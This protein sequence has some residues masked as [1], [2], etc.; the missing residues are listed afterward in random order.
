M[1]S[2][3]IVV[4]RFGIVRFDDGFS[5]AEVARMRSD[6]INEFSK[7]QGKVVLFTDLSGVTN[8]KPEVRGPVTKVLIADNPRVERNAI[9]VSSGP[10]AMQAH[11]VIRDAQSRARR[12]FTDRDELEAWIADLLTDEEKAALGKALRP[13]Q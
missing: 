6:V 10:V 9:L 2:V 1:V 12:V 4:G 11:N 5:V 13:D 7:V 8:I 3:R